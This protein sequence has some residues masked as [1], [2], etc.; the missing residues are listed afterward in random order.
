[1]SKE[2]SGIFPN[3]LPANLAQLKHIFA[4]RSGHLTD[5]PKNQ[6]TLSRIANDKTLYKGTDKWGKDWYVEPLGNGGQHWVSVKDGVIQD[7]GYNRTPKNWTPST[8][9]SSPVR[10]AGPKTT[11][12][13]IKPKKKGSK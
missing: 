12:P 10:P 9:L 8:G 1:M 4:K 2:A 11:K 13:K 6:S 7:G 5:T 3:R